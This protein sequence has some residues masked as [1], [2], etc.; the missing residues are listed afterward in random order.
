[1]SLWQLQSYSVNGFLPT[2]L[3]Q[4]P[5]NVRS[6]IFIDVIQALVMLGWILAA[7]CNLAVVYGLVHYN[8]NFLTPMPLGLSAFYQTCAR[9]AWGLGLAW[10]IF[11]CCRGY[12]GRLLFERH[13]GQNHSQ[14]TICV[15]LP[16]EYVKTIHAST[17]RT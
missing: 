14:S 7:A 9:T 2:S 15:V 1:M 5:V 16:S 3:C 6:T 11:A 12:G 13:C 8:G 10:V 4:F 17:T